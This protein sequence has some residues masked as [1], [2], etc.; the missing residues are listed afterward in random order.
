MTRVS[1]VIIT[2]SRAADLRH[3]LG[4]LATQS[5]PL[6]E[7]I[8]IDNDSV[9]ETTEL[10]SNFVKTV[11]F[12]I[13]L[14]TERKVGYPGPRNRGLVTA[15]YSWV[16]FIDDDCVAHHDWYR[17]LKLGIKRHPQA[18]A[19][20]GRAETYD[21]K[22]VF[23]V[24]ENLKISLGKVGTISDQGQITDLEIL[25][26]KN[27]VYS[28]AF[29]TEKNIKFDESL[30]ELGGGASEDCDLGMQIQQSGGSAFYH[31]Q[32]LVWHQDPTSLVHYFRKLWVVTNDHLNYESKWATYRRHLTSN[33]QRNL[34]SSINFFWQQLIKQPIIF[35]IKIAIILGVSFLVVK[36]LRL[37]KTSQESENEI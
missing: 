18:A 29:L 3:C 1:V 30:L 37:V 5:L 17:Q 8:I 26:S 2:K 9:D 36:V 23:S 25:D 15:A 11:N 35:R 27:I 12:K 21:E 22:N 13:R 16:A 7:L 31:P 6:D 28:R 32:M 14:I 20:L 4:S 10:V 33:E 34:T 24:A 19:I